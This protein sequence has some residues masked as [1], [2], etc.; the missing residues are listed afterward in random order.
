VRVALGYCRLHGHR[1]FDCRNNRWEFQ[2]HAIA[3]V[4]DDPA[5]VAA[6]NRVDSGEVSAQG[7]RGP[8]LV[9]THQPTVASHVSSHNGSE[10][11][12]D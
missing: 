3:G 10:T 8:D 2:Q 5:A 1:A 6:D 9:Q 12:G 11:A 7:L 4:L